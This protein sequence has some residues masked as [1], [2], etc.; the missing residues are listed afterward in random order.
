MGSSTSTYSL[1]IRLNLQRQFNLLPIQCP[2]TT[3]PTEALL[4]V[5]PLQHPVS[6]VL[7][8]TARS[9]NRAHLDRIPPT[10][11]P[12]SLT[13]CPSLSPWLSFLS[14]LTIPTIRGTGIM[15]FCPRPAVHSPLQCLLHPHEGGRSRPPCLLLCCRSLPHGVTGVVLCPVTSLAS[16]CDSHSAEE[17]AS[18]WPWAHQG[19]GG[20]I[21][22][23][24][25]S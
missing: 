13:D 9:L 24:R 23:R 3:Q 8:N 19:L 10:E 17:A 22:Q 16:P 1:N 14:P 20:S 2:I 4:S 5:I 25:A 18:P 15:M 6:R 11:R 21:W 12:G 7:R